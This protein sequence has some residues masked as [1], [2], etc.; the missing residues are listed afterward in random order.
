MYH[1][2]PVVDDQS[3][4]EI[5]GLGPVAV[6]GCSRTPGKPSHDVPA[7]LLS[8]GYEIYPVNPH[9]D[10]IF[11]RAVA[12]SI[13]DIDEMISLV[14]VFRPSEEVPGIVSA[15]LRRD[16]VRAIWL[17]LG[18]THEA[19]LREAENA[20]LITVQDRCMKIEHARLFDAEPN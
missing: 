12:D 8:Q 19:A 17:Q 10:E 1:E 13:V 18:I 6:I 16:D 4:K 2:M 11:G 7:Y 9:A 15:I 3:L 5:L 14:T 20:G